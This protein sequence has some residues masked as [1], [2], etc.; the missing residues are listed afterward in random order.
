MTMWYYSW[1]GHALWL[2]VAAFAVD[3]A[4]G[5]PACWP[6]PVRWVGRLLTMLQRP[7]L[8][9][10]KH[11]VAA[12]AGAL[13]FALLVAGCAAWAALLLPGLSWLVA[14]YL[15]YSGLALGC[16]LREGVSALNTLEHGNL[17]DGRKAVSMLV[18]R[19]V[20]M[21]DRQALMRT[22]AESLSENFTDGFVAPFF[23]LLLGGPVGM[24]L[25]KTASTADSMWGY[26][27]EPWFK[28]G[29][30]AAR[31]DDVLAFVP[32]RLSVLFLVLAGKLPV[33]A[34]ANGALRALQPVQW[35]ILARQAR[36][37]ESPNAGWSMAAA[38][39]LHQAR[40][41]GPAVYAGKVKQKPL[42]GPSTG[43]WDAL[44][45]RNLL[46]HLGLSGVIACILLCTVSGVV[47]LF[48]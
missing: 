33:Y 29:R 9:C 3:M 30:A 45:V 10:Q 22:L 1:H 6:H 35:A 23:W 15:A 4:L 19:D 44:C 40:M 47:R 34:V 38:A 24:W 18:S 32:A 25:Y 28:R 17:E 13:A 11:C 14:L 41:G 20:S 48:L 21:L 36:S 16:L 12:G 31:L 8:G 37:M 27:H 26:C 42:L 43:E 2:P 46:L 5:D 7:L 39:L